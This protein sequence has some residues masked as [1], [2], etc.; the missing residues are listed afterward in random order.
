[1]IVLAIDTG[2]EGGIVVKDIDSGKIIC[3]EN[4]SCKNMDELIKYVK[5]IIRKYKPNLCLLEDIS[6]TPI[7]NRKAF[8]KLGQSIAIWYTLLKLKKIDIEFV[9]NRKWTKE[10]KKFPG[11]NMKEKVYFYVRKKYTNLVPKLNN[12]LVHISDALGMIDWWVRA[13]TMQILN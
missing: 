1:M 11:K 13:R 10:Y 5:K 9:L 2:F 4:Y 6:I 12:K 3:A 8:Y 7:I